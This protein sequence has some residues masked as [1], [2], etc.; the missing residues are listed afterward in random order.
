[1]REAVTC[2][3]QALAALNPLPDTRGKIER[4]LERAVAL[5]REWNI[6]SQTPT[7]MA[8]LGHVYAWSGRIEEGVSCL[9][10]ALTA[11]ESAGSGIATRSASSSSAR[12]ICSPT[13]SRT[14]APSPTAP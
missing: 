2:F 14:P 8:S 12:R 6:T 10:Q 1:M 9:E 4:L 5:C 3:E 11:Y 13:R 7:A